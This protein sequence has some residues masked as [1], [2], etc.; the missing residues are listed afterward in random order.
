M[1]EADKRM[2]FPHYPTEFEKGFKEGQRLERKRVSM[3]LI[4][5]RKKLIR[6][7]K[8]MWNT[9]DETLYMDIRHA[10]NLGGLA[11]K[12]N[13]FNLALLAHG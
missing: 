13:K 1:N 2:K 11:K 6:S 3:V 5:L 4:N 7:K 8:L 9:D 12:S 10:L